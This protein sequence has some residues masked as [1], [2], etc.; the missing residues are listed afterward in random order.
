ML[1]VTVQMKYNADSYI[2]LSVQ[3]VHH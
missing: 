1:T 3:W 2:P